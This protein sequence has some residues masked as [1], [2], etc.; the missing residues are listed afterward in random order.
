[1]KAYDSYKNSGLQWLS[2]I[3]SHWDSSKIKSHFRLRS[4]KV[5]DQD[6]Q[7]LSVSKNGVTPQLE[8]AVKTD[9]GDN[10]KLVKAGDF[11]VNSRSDRKG[12]CGVSP[13]D[14][15]VSLINIVL[16]PIDGYAQYYHHL[17][18]CHDYIEEFYRNG[19]GIVSDLWTTRW[20]E[21]SSIMIPFPPI[22]EQKEIVAFLNKRLSDIE[23]FLVGKQQ[24]LELIKESIEHYMFCGDSEDEC[25]IDSW[26][27]TFPATW[28]MIRGKQL[29]RER[30]VKGQVNERFL[31]ATQ[32]KGVVYKDECEANFVTASD[33]RTQKL[34][35]ENDF[36][37]SLRSFQGGIEFSRVRGIISAAYVVM[38]LREHFDSPELRTFYRFLLKSRPFVTLLGSLSDSLRDGKSIKYEEF[39]QFY[40]PI[41]DDTILR[42]VNQLAFE[43]DTRCVELDSLKTLLQEYKQRLISDVV[44]G[45]IDVR[46]E[47]RE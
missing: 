33:P 26:Q 19:R 47:E 10:R 35:C 4:T 1:M 17:F 9:N 20:K 31:A 37:I 44:T 13:L 30:N 3:P 18:R 29:F 23:A 27:G 8:T 24:Q 21:M 11:V 7:A 41:P 16:E 12:A 15:S 38:H 36:V 34:V 46:N 2:K 45:Q 42:K 40:Y 39:G 28:K 32:N 5:S 25:V 6:Y 14:G 43:Y 22:E